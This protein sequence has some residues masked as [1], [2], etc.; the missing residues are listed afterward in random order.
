MGR[1][2]TSKMNITSITVY[3]IPLEVTILRAETVKGVIRFRLSTDK[4]RHDIGLERS[5][6]ATAIID[7]SN[8]NLN[9]GVIL[10]SNETTSGRATVSR[11]RS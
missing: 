3:K 4:A 6:H 7:I 8:V 2:D 10:G 5:S 9:R 11:L 1:P